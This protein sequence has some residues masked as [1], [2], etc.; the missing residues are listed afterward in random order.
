MFEAEQALDIRSVFAGNYNGIATHRFEASLAG[1]TVGQ[2]Q[3]AINTQTHAASIE[4]LKLPADPSQAKNIARQLL[5]FASNKFGFDELHS[6]IIIPHEVRDIFEPRMQARSKSEYKISQFDITKLADI[7]SYSGRLKYCKQFLT[8]MGKG[9]GRAVFDLGNS[10]VLKLAINAKGEAQ[11][12]VEADWALQDAYKG[13][14]AS[15]LDQA[16]DDYSWVISEKARKITAKEF[17][18]KI[19]IKFSDFAW[20]VRQYVLWRQGSIRGNPNIPEDVLDNEF[21]QELTDM[22]LNFSHEPGD[23]A[24]IDS[25]GDIDGDIVVRDYGLSKATWNDHYMKPAQRRYY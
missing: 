18:E 25:Y 5:E 21:F 12:Q 19:G 7:K 3:L 13:I 8:Q 24:K 22:A 14:I 11:N 4:Q 2:M 16:P 10:R 20:D 9:S 23:Y 15:V 6:E 1:N 17:K